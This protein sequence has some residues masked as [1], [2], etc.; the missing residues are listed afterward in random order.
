MLL[1]NKNCYIN[2]IILAILLLTGCA[3][4]YSRLTPEQKENTK[5]NAAIK[6]TCREGSDCSEKWS[7]AINWVVQVS[8]WKIQTQ[9]DNL[10]QTFGSVNQSMFSAFTVNKTAISPGIYE[11]KIEAGCSNMIGCDQEPAIWKALFNLYVTGNIK[12]PTG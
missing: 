2:L 5:K 9:T 3:S 6:V 1:K 11:I 12:T 10:I 4:N 8:Q 7:R